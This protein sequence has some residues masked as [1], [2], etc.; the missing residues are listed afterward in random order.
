MPMETTA[1]VT[2]QCPNCSAGLSFDPAKQKFC[3]EF[4]L[5]EFS[6]SELDNTETSK[7]AEDAASEAAE[8]AAEAS[9]IPDEEYCA[10]MEEYHCS[11]C[12][13]NIICDGTTA[14][15][16]CPYCHSPVIMA[17]RLAGQMRPHKIIPFKFDK[18]QA[19]ECFRAFMKK[20]WFV[21]RSFLAE[22][23]LDRI[24][25]V[26]YPFWCTDAD[27]SAAMTARATRVRTWRMGDYRYTE[28]SNFHIHRK[29][30]IHFE[31][32]VTPAITE[33]DREML[34]GILPYPSDSLQDFS[35][36]Y[37]SGFVAKKRDI[38]K[39]AVREAVRARMQS[40]AGTLLRG[41]IHGYTTVNPSAP[42]LLTK[43]MHWDYTLMPIWLLTYNR[44]GKTYTY[45]M[46]GY[47]GKIYGE[48]PV[49]GKKLA[50]LGSLVGVASA[51]LTALCYVSMI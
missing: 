50:V 34:D 43:R 20:K 6:K 10:Q 4:C 48:I 44:R 18:E 17:G 12:G 47:T 29:G 37:L 26:Y 7:A 8:R 5:S 22:A 25:G 16:T 35:M 40:Y 30:E 23:Q 38:E 14:A 24:S 32:I 27:T 46:N 31:D 39:E 2:Y 41:T 11:N 33:E 28:T 42:R 9:E 49:S 3:C 51:A 21:P 13:A 45:A 36:P 1:T 15:T 19:K